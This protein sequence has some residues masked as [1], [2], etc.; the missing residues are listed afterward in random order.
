MDSNTIIIILLLIF[1]VIFSIDVYIRVII[2]YEKFYTYKEVNY[3]T[4]K[5]INNMNNFNKIQ[6]TIPKSKNICENNKYMINKPAKQYPSPILKKK[7][8]QINKNI[9]NSLNDSVIDI[10]SLNSMVSIDSKNMND[11][12]NDLQFVK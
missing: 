5:E 4:N 9:D 8:K 10:K 12:L 7:N 6:H 11:S 3:N 2:N 1:I